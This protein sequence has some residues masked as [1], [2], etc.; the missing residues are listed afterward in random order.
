MRLAVAAFT[1]VALAAASAAA[2]DRD[3]SAFEARPIAVYAVMG[4]GTPVG[5]MGAELERTLEPHWT[6][7]AGAGWGLSG[8]QGSAMTHFLFGD[9][10]RSRFVVGAGIS[11]GRY[12]WRESCLVDCDDPAEK[13]GNVMWAN[14]EVGGEHRF[15]GGFAIRYF[16]GYGHV[17]AGDLVCSSD[18][19]SGCAAMSRETGRDIL[20]S[21][22]ALGGAF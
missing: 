3:V 15:F 9:S 6:I 8:F 22:V 7:S 13:T 5:L 10:T 19:S 21:G 1:L 16:A 2:D 4:L 12:I 18:A 20:Y 14:L 11:G 17:V